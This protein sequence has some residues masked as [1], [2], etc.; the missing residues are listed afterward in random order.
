MKS[1]GRHLANITSRVRQVTL[2][3]VL[4]AMLL[5][6]APARA[7]WAVYDHPNFAL[8]LREFIEELNHWAQTIDHYANM[9]EKAAQQVT[10]LGGILT[11][12]DKTLARNK[13][14][15]TTFSNVGK[16]VRGVFQL[17]R[18]LR[19]MIHCRI[20][21]IESVTQRLKHGVFDMAANERDLE[22]YL[23]NTIGKSADDEIARIE[24]L[25]NQDATLERLRYE[26]SEVDAQISEQED[27]LKQ[28]EQMLEE[29]SKKEAH[30]Q[31]AIDVITHQIALC[32]QTLAELWKQ[33]SDLLSKIEERVKI[34]GV[35]LE[36]RGN[37][38]NQV[39]EMN[40][41]L[42]GLVD[43]KQEIIDAIN[44]EF[45]PDNLLPDPDSLD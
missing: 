9:Y 20:Q 19:N 8:K 2:G 13:E 43:A 24:R 30:D 31:Y 36:E 21:A 15:I 3:L 11:V 23:K 37:F 28:Y 34:Y 18:Q 40:D 27:T 38:A 7:Q 26:L 32:K 41:A 14:M 4:G 33:R 12:V 42:R 22:V 6:P 16:A 45:E 44:E 5:S 1:N 25:A 29:A 39:Q 17:H 10:S 35:V